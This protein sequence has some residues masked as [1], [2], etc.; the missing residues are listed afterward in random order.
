MKA[1]FGVVFILIAA[2]SFGSELTFRGMPFSFTERQVIRE[3]GRPDERITS[4]DIALW[5]DVILAYENVSVA[6]YDAFVE[7]ELDQSGILSGVYVIQLPENVFGIDDD[8]FFIDAYL[9]FI[10]RLN[11]LYGDPI[12]TRA[13]E[14]AEQYSSLMKITIRSQSPYDSFWDVD[15]AEVM[16]TLRHEGFH[17]RLYLMYSSPHFVEMMHAAEEQNRRSTE[18]L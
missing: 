15:G 16:L 2:L 8:A 1:I 5:G 14:G 9:D 11:T 3:M 4:D 13:P 6:G 18:G 7:I 17:W 12:K 10:R